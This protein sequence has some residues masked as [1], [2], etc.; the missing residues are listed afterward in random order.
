MDTPALPKTA[1]AAA[2][3]PSP[4]PLLLVVDDREENLVAMQALLGDSDDWQLRC[5]DS[6]EKALRCLL[7][8]DVSLVLLDVQMPGMDGYEVAE[9]M[10]GNPNTRYTPIIFISAIAR[11]QELILRG[12]NTGAMDFILKPFDSAVLLQKVHNLLAHEN[13]R[14]ALQRLTQTL[15]RERAFNAAIL[16][17]AAEGIMVV[18]EDGRI[19][20]ANPTMAQMADIDLDTL[21][22]S[23]FLP[24]IQP[25]DDTTPWPESAFYQHWAA[26]Q[27]YR[28]HDDAKDA[29]PYLYTA[30]GGQIPVTLSCAP[31]PAPHKAMTVIVRD[32]TVEL[33][34]KTRMEAL[35]VTD[36]LTGLLNRRG[37]FKALD[38][39]LAR[40]KRGD[41]QFALLYLDL[42]GFK[43]INDSLGHDA[44][45]ELLHHVAAQLK[46]GLRTY[47]PLARM[48]GDEFTVLLEEMENIQ[49]AARVADKLMQLVSVRQYIGGEEFTMTASIGIAGYP[50][51]GT[52]AETLL[53]AADIAMYEAKNTGRQRYCFHSAEITARARARLELEKRLR[54][55]VEHQYFALVY[56]PQFDLESGHLRG[57]EALLRWTRGN[58]EEAGP[59]KFIPLL[60]ETR[61]INPLGQWIFTEG[62]TRL[63]ELNRVFACKPKLSINVSPVQFA[64]P[65]L[66]EGIAELLQKYAL[67]PAQLEVEVTE[68]VLLQDLKTTHTHLR[69]LR[70]LGVKVAV[71]D[72]GTGY[73]SL[74]YLSD[75]DLD[76]LKIDRRFISNMQNSGRDAAVVNSIIDLSGHL[77][78]QVIAEGVETSGQRQ[79]FLD[80]DYHDIII[81]GWLVAPGLSPEEAMR[82]PAQLDW[83]SLPLAKAA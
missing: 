16:A 49:D 31:L 26:G 65:R 64:Q 15:D 21:T 58:P 13:N 56:Q 3:Q 73:S 22:G 34:L 43:R 81:Q 72:F 55:A 66:V 80:K 24:L 83:N 61:L 28:V 42:D 5:V 71:D 11:T 30:N 39:A 7:H 59:I 14:R 8:E 35:I 50:E 45:D 2:V 46:S 52:D 48:G 27:T 23:A 57:F 10:R 82:V 77:G 32:T 63:Q 68:S 17:N 29:K 51:S 74:A 47:D 67:D 36:P 53:R 33:D 38:Q 6:G 9:L 75:F 18:G 79:W 19:Q 12:Y 41:T 4:P 37:F 25:A 1:T 69:E 70:T 76:T 62:L 60:E 78:L 40:A 54:D 20:F 44:G